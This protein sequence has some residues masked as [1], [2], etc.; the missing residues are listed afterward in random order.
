MSQPLRVVLASLLLVV[1][2][3]GLATVAD[4]ITMTYFL[5]PG[6]GGMATEHVALFG[7]AIAGTVGAAVAV[8]ALVVHLLVVIRRR[9]P[10]WVWIAATVCALLAV[11][12]PVIVSMSDRPAF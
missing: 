1:A 11:G 10:G 5:P 9:T 2:V 7:P 6:E 3:V 8:A 12:A 4:Q